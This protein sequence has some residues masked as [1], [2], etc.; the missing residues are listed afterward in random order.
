MQHG[1]IG[2][3]A[4]KKFEFFEIFNQFSILSLSLLCYSI[5]QSFVSRILRNRQK[6]KKFNLYFFRHT[7]IIRTLNYSIY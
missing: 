3:R 7:F 2:I 4:D 6:L 5:I 1:K